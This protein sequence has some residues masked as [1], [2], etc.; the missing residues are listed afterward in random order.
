MKKCI[1]ICETYECEGTI[2][3]CICIRIS[4]VYNSVETQ[5]L[6]AGPT[7]HLNIK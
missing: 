3:C 4:R 1:P 5:K 6:N 2:S 7:S